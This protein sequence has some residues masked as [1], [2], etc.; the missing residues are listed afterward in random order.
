MA[1]V[2]TVWPAARHEFLAPKTARAVASAAGCDMDTGFID[3]HR[4]TVSV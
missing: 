4:C 2:A 3:K 1:T